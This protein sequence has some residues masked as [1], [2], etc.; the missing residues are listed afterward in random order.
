MYLSWRVSKSRI[1][2]SFSDK[3]NNSINSSIRNQYY[4]VWLEVSNMIKDKEIYRCFNIDHM[5]ITC[6][7]ISIM[8]NDYPIYTFPINDKNRDDVSNCFFILYEMVLR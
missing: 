4:N 1:E 8:V 3:D 2:F 7:D 5:Q 6:D